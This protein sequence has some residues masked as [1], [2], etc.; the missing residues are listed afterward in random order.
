MATRSFCPRPI[1]VLPATSTNFTFSTLTTS[2]NY[3]FSCY[4]PNGFL[5]QFAGNLKADCGQIEAVSY[6]NPITDGFKI[7]LANPGGVPTVFTVTNGWFANSLATY[8]V[9]A[10]S[11]NIVF[12]DTSTN[13]VGVATNLFGVFTNT[14]WY[15]LT[16]TASSD[17]QF[18]RRFAGHIETSATPPGINSSENPSG[19]KDL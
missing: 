7:T 17:S 19:F 1:D 5:R 8:T 6:L 16:V 10:N 3:N 11:T 12:L 14:G 2:G 9:P 4:G 18:V 13:N 15:D